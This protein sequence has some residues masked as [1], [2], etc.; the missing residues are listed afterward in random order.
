MGRIKDLSTLKNSEY[1]A[2]GVE[3]EFIRKNGMSHSNIAK[4]IRDKNVE[5]HAEGYNHN[6]RSYWKI[7]GDSSVSA[8][9]A[10]YNRNMIGSNELVSPILKGAEGFKQIEIICEVL[11]EAGCEI[12]VTCGLHVHH[13]IRS[14]KENVLSNRSS[15]LSIP[16]TIL[17]LGFKSTSLSIILPSKALI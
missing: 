7:V 4:L 2:F 16:S 15:R 1:R 9:S 13:D 14:W 10:Q 11:N 17:R 5:C 3:I 6:T 8:N 12:N